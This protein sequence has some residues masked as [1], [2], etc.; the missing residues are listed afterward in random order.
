MGEDKKRLHDKCM[1]VIVPAIEEFTQGL[2]DLPKK[3]VARIQGAAAKLADSLSTGLEALL[4]GVEL[5]SNG[6]KTQTSATGQLYK[7][8]N[9]HDFWYYPDLSYY[10]ISDRMPEINKV[11]AT[12]ESPAHN[13]YEQKRAKI[14]RYLID[15]LD[16]EISDNTISNKFNFHEGSVLEAMKVLI[17]KFNRSSYYEIL[18]VKERVPPI[19]QQGVY[20][21][22][23]KTQNP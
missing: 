10:Q 22:Q 14:A 6:Q 13:E 12:A 2:S 19:N 20:K 1:E 8:E 5:A 21:M 23:K 4:E 16:K 3:H 11:V 17:Q 15:N 18:V 9:F 7:V